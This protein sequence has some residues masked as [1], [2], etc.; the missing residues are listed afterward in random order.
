MP[1]DQV[2]VF[3]KKGFT[4]HGHP[5]TS[6]GLGA[7]V[8]RVGADC[9]QAFLSEL[10]KHDAFYAPMIVDSDILDYTVLGRM[11]RRALGQRLLR[12]RTSALLAG[13]DFAGAPDIPP[14]VRALLLDF[15]EKARAAGSRPMV[16]LIEDRGY[17]GVL[18]KM[19][20]PVLAAKQIEFISTSAVAASNDPANFIADGHFKP[21][22]NRALA[23]TLLGM[24]RGS[25]KVMIPAE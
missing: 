11:V 7:K 18:S 3:A 15:A 17:G 4:Y 6:A 8:A 12:D 20:V 21:E 22:I 14:L 24:L 25:G 10:A 13:G 5:Y 16:I 9:G 2:T 23:R 19:L 1:L